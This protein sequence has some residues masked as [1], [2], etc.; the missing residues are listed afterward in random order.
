MICRC[1][2]RPAIGKN[3]DGE[4]A[5]F[6]CQGCG[7]PRCGC[8]A[9]EQRVER[10]SNQAK[11][12]ISYVCWNCGWTYRGVDPNRGGPL[13]VTSAALGQEIM[14]ADFERQYLVWVRNLPLELRKASMSRICAHDDQFISVVI[15]RPAVRVESSETDVVVSCRRCERRLVNRRVFLGSI[16]DSVREEARGRLMDELRGAG[17]LEDESP[18]QWARRVREE[19]SRAIRA[20]GEQAQRDIRNALNGGATRREVPDPDWSSDTMDEEER[21]PGGRKVEL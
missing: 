2:D 7:L 4:G 8:S 15:T 17:L 1:G 21:T 5:Y 11:G 16:I 9:L 10:V 13:E 18:I 3:P 20:A 12:E 19:A 6:E 14:A